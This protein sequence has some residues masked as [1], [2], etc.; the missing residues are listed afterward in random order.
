MKKITISPL[1]AFAFAAWLLGAAGCGGMGGEGGGMGCGPAQPP[2]PPLDC[3]AGSYEENGRCK[4]MTSQQRR[5]VQGNNTGSTTS[6][7]NGSG[8]AP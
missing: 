5:Q 8:N 2:A 1:A 7:S 3:P 6:N 4:R